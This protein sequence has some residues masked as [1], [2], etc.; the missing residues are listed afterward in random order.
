MKLDLKESS[1]I[2]AA[3]YVNTTLTV[4]FASGGIYAY[5]D[6]PSDVIEQWLAA[7]SVGKSFHQLIKKPGFAYQKIADVSEAI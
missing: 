5:Y 7:E 4:T 1:N 2:L 6:V 3:S